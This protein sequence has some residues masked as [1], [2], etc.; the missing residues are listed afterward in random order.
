MSKTETLS[1][2]LLRLDG[3]TQARITVSEETIEEYSELIK[4]SGSQ[5]PFGPLDVYHDGTDYFVSD[6]F[7]R[8]LAA[9]KAGRASVP[10]DVKKGTAR[11]ARMHGMLANDLHGLR[12]SREDRRKNVVWLLDT[13][14]TL[15]QK[16]VATKAG[17]SVRTV[18][19]VVASRKPVNPQ[20][21]G[22]ET[23]ET[24]NPGIPSP[25]TRTVT[26][27]QKAAAKAKAKAKAAASKE[28]A[29]ADAAAAKA[30]KDKEKAEA[31]AEKARAKAEAAGARQKIKD[32]AA[33][34]KAEAQA[35]KEAAKAATITPGNQAKLN[36]KL[37]Q[38]Y[39]DKAVRAVD[40]LNHVKPNHTIR[41][42]VVKM[43]QE[44][45]RLLW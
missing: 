1:L 22:S 29:K 32:D 14:P 41:V 24:S 23:F 2:D 16:E 25:P 39:I 34:A 43:L 44:A 26:P 33:E 38:A 21:A 20:V 28:K 45:G 31:V 4:S 7:H 19:T 15:P 10:C 35:A 42:R 36:R 5:W 37:A 27:K 13:F 9:I 17:V 11:D 30:V 8:T 40:D 6:G 18:E 12:M 3:D